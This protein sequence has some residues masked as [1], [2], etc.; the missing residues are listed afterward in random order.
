MSLKR[1]LKFPKQ[2]GPRCLYL[3]LV[4][5]LIRSKMETFENATSSSMET[6][7]I[8]S[9][10]NVATTT[11]LAPKSKE[12]ECLNKGNDNERKGSNGNTTVYL[13]GSVGGNRVIETVRYHLKIE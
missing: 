12:K 9:F 1:T 13:Q 3:E 7:N 4:L 5:H 8:E 2:V 11:D 6:V 10:E